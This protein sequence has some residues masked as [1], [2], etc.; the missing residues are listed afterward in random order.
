MTDDTAAMT[1]DLPEKVGTVGDRRRGSDPDDAS[2]D[3]DRHPTIAGT[4]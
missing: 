3:R 4:S 2:A 1:Q